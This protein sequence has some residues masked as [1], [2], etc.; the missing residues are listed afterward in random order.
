MSGGRLFTQVTRTKAA[1]S[2]FDDPIFDPLSLFASEQPI[3]PK[4]REKDL[5]KKSLSNLQELNYD[6]ANRSSSDPSSAIDL[7]LPPKVDT[8]NRSWNDNIGEKQIEKCFSHERSVG[9]ES[10]S[11]SSSTGQLSSK[12]SAK[13]V[14]NQYSGDSSFLTHKSYNIGEESLH[15]K[16]VA[17]EIPVA[18][19]EEDDSDVKIQLLTGEQR[20]MSIIDAFVQTSQGKFT[21]GTLYMTNYRVAFIPSAADLSVIADGNPS[22]FSWLHIPLAAIDRIEKERRLV[23]YCYSYLACDVATLSYICTYICMY[24]YT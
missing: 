20:V 14:R 10:S 4:V 19:E 21:S 8:I 1:T 12:T 7:G 13:S 2:A 17:A 9:V 5:N 23:A 18:T 24:I 3:Q 16:P 15:S 6:A 22:V 11:C